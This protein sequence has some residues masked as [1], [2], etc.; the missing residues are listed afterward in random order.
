[1]PGPRYLMHPVPAEVEKYLDDIADEMA[2]RYG[3]P[4]AEAVARIN[5]HWERETFD[6]EDDLIFHELP[7]F[8]AGLIYYGRDAAHWDPD[9]DLSATQPHPAPPADSPAWTL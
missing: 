2:S 8:W 7:E 6:E 4:L 3:I 5:Q 1:M 9:A